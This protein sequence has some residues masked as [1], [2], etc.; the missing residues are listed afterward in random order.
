MTR[1]PFI[2]TFVITS[3]AFTAST[4]PINTPLLVTT[5]NQG[6]PLQTYATALPEG[7][8][9]SF[10]VEIGEKLGI[11]VTY[12]DKRLKFVIPP[13]IDLSLGDLLAE[14]PNL[15]S[16]VRALPSPISD[17]LSCNVRGMDFDATA[18]TL[19]VAATLS[20]LTIIP[21]MME[22]NNLHIALVTILSSN[23]S[24]LQSVE[25]S[26]D[27]VLRDANIRVNVS[28][29]KASSEVA[30]D[31]ILKEGLNLT[32]LMSS[33]TDSNLPIPSAINSVRLIKIIGRKRGSVT[34][35]IFSGIIYSKQSRCPLD[36]SEYGSNFSYCNSS[37]N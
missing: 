10:E 14:I 4:S 6:G 1:V 3:L 9:A 22:V 21:E 2:S 29:D 17:L 16:V 36:I 20:R 5:F 34:T 18:K 24:G 32:Q 25:F 30:F 23:T 7:E 35:I 26:A 33:L 13:E 31:A 12:E 15:G 19:S 37:W 8:T 27:W 11:A 28:Y